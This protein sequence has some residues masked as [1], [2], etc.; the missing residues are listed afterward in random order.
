MKLRICWMF[1]FDK[2]EHKQKNSVL[3]NCSHNIV[4]EVASVL[5]RSQ[6]C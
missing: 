3:I 4:A 1:G 2:I 5:T 6:V